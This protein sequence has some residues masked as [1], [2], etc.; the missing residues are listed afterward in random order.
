M[1]GTP[2]WH[3]SEV[4]LPFQWTMLMDGNHPQSFM[5][6]KEVAASCV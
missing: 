1:L 2:A 4:L 5:T 3:A 6:V